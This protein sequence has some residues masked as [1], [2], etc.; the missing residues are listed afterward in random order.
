MTGRILLI[1][2]LLLLAFMTV[3]FVIAKLRN[4]IDTVDMAW[5]LGFVISAVAVAVQHRTIACFLIAL[6]VSVWGLRLSIHI[7]LRARSRG[8][9]PRYEAMS[10]KWKG[11]KWLRAYVSIFLLQGI[12]IW[13]V[14]LPIMLAANSVI[15]GLL[16]LNI[17]GD[18]VWAVGFVI[19]AM[20]DYQLSKFLKRKNHPKVM[21]EGLWHYSRHPNYFGELTQWWGIGI[22]CLQVSYGWLGLLGPLSLSL[23]I[24]FVSGIPPIEKRHQKDPAYAAYTAR[25][26]SLI[27]LPPK[28]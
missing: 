12:L 27:P 11:N 15:H 14:G 10:K 19:E 8:E 1:N 23:L 21:Q 18:I 9:D 24:I 17:V 7:G 16:W 26:S 4:R 25:T 13:I 6:L 28:S 5:G 3:A 22:I 2:G 20:S